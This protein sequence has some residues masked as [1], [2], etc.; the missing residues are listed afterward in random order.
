MEGTVVTASIGVT[1]IA[2]EDRSYED[3]L[4]R[5]DRALYEAK[6]LGKDRIVSA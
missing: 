2:P 3:T 6:G 5:A 1:T 4:K